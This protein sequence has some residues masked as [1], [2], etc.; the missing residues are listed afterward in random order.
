MGLREGS[1]SAERII[2]ARKRRRMKPATIA[3]V[4]NAKDHALLE[5]LSDDLEIQTF[6]KEVMEGNP[7]PLGIVL[8]QRQQQTKE[9]EEF[10]DYVEELLSQPFLK[11]EIQEHALKWLRSKVR[12]EE[13]QKRESEAAEVIADYA[14]KVFRSDPDRTDFLLAGPTNKVRVRVF[15]LD[16][17]KQGLSQAA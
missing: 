7:N 5:A 2:S 13:Y 6:E 12:I 16:A 4:I 1:R 11:T 10:G 14:L 15:V 17:D 9:E 8:R 3:L